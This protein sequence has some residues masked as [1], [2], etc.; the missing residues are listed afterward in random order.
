[1]ELN[2]NAMNQVTK[3]TVILAE[4]DPVTAICLVVKGRITCINN[5]VRTVVGSGSFLGICDLPHEFY[6]VTYEAFDDSVIYPFAVKDSD[7]VARIMGVNKEYGALM[8]ISLNRYIKELA[9]IYLSLSQEAE[10]FTSFLSVSYA[11]YGEIV[12]NCGFPKVKI[13]SLEEMEPFTMPE[14]VKRGNMDYFSACCDL[15]LDVQKAYYRLPAISAFHIEQEVEMVTQLISG[16]MELSLYLSE[17]FVGLMDEGENCLFKAL[18]KLAF[19]LKDKSAQAEISKIIDGAVDQINQIENTLTEKTG[20]KINVE[21]E[22]MEKAYYQL[23]SGDIPTGGDADL[24][25]NDSENYDEEVLD[26]FDNSLEKILDFSE[27]EDEVRNTFIS[28]IE[29]YKNLSDK[30]STEDKARNLRRN[31]TKLYYQIYS[32]VFFKACET[33]DNSKLI[34][35]FLNYGYMDENLLTRE[36]LIELY[37]L[38]SREEQHGPC[39]VFSIREWLEAIYNGEKEPSKSEMDMDYTEHLRERKKNKEITEAEMKEL[40]ENRIEK[41][42]YEIHNMLTY[43]NRIISGQATIFIPVLHQESFMGSVR[44]AKLDALHINAAVNK[45]VQIDYSAFYRQTLYTNPEKGIEKEYIMVET[46]PDVILLPTYG[47]NGIMW[48]DIAGKRRTTPGRFLLSAFC[49]TNLDDI[50]MRLIG[51]FRWELCRTIQGIQWNDVKT[52]SLTS[53]YMDYLQFYRKN[54]ELSEEKKEKLKVQIQKAR[55][56]SR[57]VF[58]VDYVAWIKFEA[59][60]SIRLNKVVRDILATYC[61]FRKE[62]RRKLEEQPLFAASMVRFN[63]EHVK[64]MKEISLRRRTLEK[65]GVELPEELAKTYEYYEKY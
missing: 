31:I 9:K 58:V 41:V 30:T 52:K 27:V 59:Q 12:Q 65:A 44:R 23:I 32:K 10:G 50:I 61:P 53:E 57:E 56:A 11:K 6:R 3:G 38:N 5:G 60:G 45:V 7:A 34:D 63:R 35:L 37:H 62:L 48:Q 8:V 42:M 21:R 13:D 4:H 28:E 33:K 39:R 22:Y 40:E 47:T 36:Q 25:L 26:A 51:R 16:C 64:T 20:L 17:S 43:N 1:M 46:Y 49:D 15:P 55:G 29:E 14:G 2:F 18:M 24:A 54:H 19:Q